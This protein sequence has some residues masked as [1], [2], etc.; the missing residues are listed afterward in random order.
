MVCFVANHYTAKASFVLAVSIWG[1]RFMHSNVSPIKLCQQTI[2]QR[3]MANSCTQLPDLLQQLE[4]DPTSLPISDEAMAKFPLR[5]TQAY[6]SRIEKGNPNDPLLLQILPIK[7]ELN[8]HPD[9]N[10]N[11]VGDLEAGQTAGIL[12][13]YHG[14][15]L[16]I[17]TG[18]CSINCRYCF[19][20]EYPYSGNQTSKSVEHEAIDYIA[21][22]PGVSEV[23]LSG[24]DPL[25]LSDER[26]SA[27]VSKLEE[28]PHLKRLRIHTR[29]PVTLPSRVDD[30][31]L[32][33]LSETRL[34]TSIVLHV[35]HPSELDDTVSNA[36]FKLRQSG[37]TLLNQSVLLKGIN[38]SETVL[39]QLSEQLFQSGVLPYYLHLLDKVSGS[40]HFEIPEA[41]ALSLYHKIRCK[42]PGYL[43]PTLVREQPGFPYKS[44]IL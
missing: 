4:L 1:L 38:D 16:L 39:C 24:G 32:K 20:R 3:E 19:R 26:L 5:V 42:L 6:I 43:V 23:I 25:I 8:S 33:W 14:R 17:T 13:K 2:W 7:S 35:N 29:L 11:P 22:Q 34:T 30:S 9:F 21:Q 27:L 40:Q 41:D 18:G 31:L 37:I 15:L 12:H 10:N 28:I 36:L 44:P